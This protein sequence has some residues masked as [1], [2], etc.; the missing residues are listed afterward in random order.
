MFC[1][2]SQSAECVRYVQCIPF[3]ASTGCLI[4]ILHAMEIVQVLTYIQHMGKLVFIN[5][6]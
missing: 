4:Q 2:S 1:S 6:Y 5:S 3:S